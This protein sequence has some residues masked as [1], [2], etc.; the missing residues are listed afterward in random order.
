M[1][2]LLVICAFSSLFLIFTY[3][4]EQVNNLVVGCILPSLIYCI[5]CNNHSWYWNY[6]KKA[7]HLI[8]SNC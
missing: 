4:I 2:L 5:G 3:C 1:D 6:S 7:I 8:S